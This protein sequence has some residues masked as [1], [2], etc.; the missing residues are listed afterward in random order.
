MASGGAHCPYMCR[1]PPCV[2]GHSPSKRGHCQGCMPGL[3]PCVHRATACACR[4]PPVRC[5]GTASI[6][7]GLCPCVRVTSLRRPP[8]VC[9]RA[10]NL[11]YQP[12]PVRARARPVRA[13]TPDVRATRPCVAMPGQWRAGVRRNTSHPSSR[14]QVPQAASGGLTA[15]EKHMTGDF[16]N[17]MVMAF[18]FF[19]AVVQSIDC[20]QL[21]SI[22]VLHSF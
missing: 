2:P 12:L 5:A 16:T 4:L 14:R 1:P 20:A 18:C 22:S 19:F 11:L 3:C 8:L 6:C 13:R 10:V 17:L 9:A 15:Q 7:A 21:I